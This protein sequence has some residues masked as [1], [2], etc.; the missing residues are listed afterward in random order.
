VSGTTASKTTAR[1]ADPLAIRPTAQGVA[2]GE[3]R[4]ERDAGGQIVRVM[5][6]ANPLNDPLNELDDQSSEDGSA[7]GAER[8]G[9]GGSD[10]DG[11]RRETE[12][13]RELE[14][15]AA[16]PVDKPVR[17]QSGREVEWLERL[18]ASHG[19]DTAAMARDM[20]LNPMQQTEADIARR[21]RKWKAARRES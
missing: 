18:V 10:G 1:A 8:G 7:D 5:R 12:V 11:D 14:R 13:V 19:D 20:K 16:R 15:Q 2:V 6:R 21:M 3:V 17:H 9:M 4:V